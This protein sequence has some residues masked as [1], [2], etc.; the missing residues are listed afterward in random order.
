MLKQII[1]F[2][3]QSLSLLLCGYRKGFSTLKAL[4][5]LIE[6]WKFMLDKKEY[7]AAIQFDLSKAFGTVNHERLETKLNVYGFSKEAL[8]LTFNYLNNRK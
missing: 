4:P 3:N 6:K 7:A 5:Y 1:D 2:I 8:K